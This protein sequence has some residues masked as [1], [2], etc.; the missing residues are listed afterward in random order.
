VAPTELRVI[1][2]QRRWRRRVPRCGGW[3]HWEPV[4]GRNDRPSHHDRLEGL[5]ELS[6]LHRAAVPAGAAVAG[7][8]TCSTDDGVV[9]RPA[10]EAVIVTVAAQG[11]VPVLATEPVVAGAAF[12]EVVARAA[13]DA[14]GATLA[15]QHVGT[16]TAEE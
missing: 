3:T 14:V 4:T 16:V 13:G 9:A 6:R 2:R 15:A 12:E 1:S 11:V 8:I 10:T 7:I 5:A